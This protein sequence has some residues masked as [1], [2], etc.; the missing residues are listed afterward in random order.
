MSAHS[1][2]SCT[3]VGGWVGEGECSL[4]GVNWNQLKTRP[5]VSLHVSNTVYL[6]ARSGISVLSGSVPPASG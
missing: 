2:Q 5:T 4:I 6:S 1:S 3:L